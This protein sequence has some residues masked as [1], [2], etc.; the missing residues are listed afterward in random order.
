[1]VSSRD[2]HYL[3][4]DERRFL[5]SQITFGGY[6]HGVSD[7]TPHFIYFIQR[8]EQF[9]FKLNPV[10]LGLYEYILDVT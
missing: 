7:R 3:L 8:K 4:V 9:G 10:Q 6:F 5:V 2:T 1:V